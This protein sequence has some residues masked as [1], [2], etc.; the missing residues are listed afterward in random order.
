MRRASSRVSRL[1]AARRPG[2]LEVEITERLTVGVMH[3]EAGIVR[4]IDGPR[5]RETG[6]TVLR[7]RTS[8]KLRIS[9]LWHGK[10]KGRPLDALS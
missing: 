9:V 6:I 3:D 1:A 5:R 7:H 8:A 2:F 4:L 10:Q